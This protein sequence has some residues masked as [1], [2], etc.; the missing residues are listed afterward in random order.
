MLRSAC[1]RSGSAAT[2]MV[3]LLLTARVASAGVEF[4]PP[5]SY[6]LSHPATSVALGD[7][8]GDGDLDAAVG[9]SYAPA[10]EIFLNRGDGTFG[11]ID[12]VVAPAQ[13]GIVVARL[14]GDG[15]PDL[16][17]VTPDGSVSVFRG[18]GDGGFDHLFSQLAGRSASAV[19]AADLDGDGLDDLAILGAFGEDTTT[20]SLGV[21]INQNGSFA[22]P[23]GYSVRSWTRSIAAGDLNGDGRP[24]LA[25]GVAGG[26]Q[27]A[28]AVL[29]NQGDGTLGSSVSF[30]VPGGAPYA[31]IGDLDGD[32]DA[33]LAAA[34]ATTVTGLLNNGSGSFAIAGTTPLYAYAQ[35]AAVADFDGDGR[36]DVATSGDALGRVIAL[37]SAGNGT[38]FDPPL[39]FGSSPGGRGI[40]SGDV[41]GDGHPDV[42]TADLGTS[43][44]GSMTVLV[45][46]APRSCPRK[47]LRSGAG[48]SGVVAADFNADG[49]PDVAAANEDRTLAVMLN[50]GFGGFSDARRYALGTLSQ[51]LAAGDLDADGRPDLVASN[52]IEST[53]T[54][55]YNKGDGSFYGGV[56]LGV[57]PH[58]R[59]VEL[60]DVDGD[61][62]PDLVTADYNDAIYAGSVSVLRNLGNRRFAPPAS[63]AVG[64]GPY[65]VRAANMNKDEMP[66]LVVTNYDGQSVSV[67]M[68]HGDGTFANAVTYA[69]AWNL[70]VTAADFDHDGD[71][72][73]AVTNFKENSVTVLKNDGTGVLSHFARIPVG[74]Q[75]RSIQAAIVKGDG[76]V[77]LVVALSGTSQV[78][79]L[80]NDGSGLFTVSSSTCIVGVNPKA[81]IVTD[82]DH[83]AGQDLATANTGAG[84]IT[85]LPDVGPPGS[86][87]SGTAL[88]K[89]ARR[90]DADAQASARF[91]LGA[92]RPNPARGDA[93]IPFEIPRDALVDLRVYDVAGRVVRTLVSGTVSAGPHEAHWNGADDRGVRMA[94]GTYFYR[95]RAGDQQAVRALMLR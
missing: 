53:V 60:A 5:V 82:F 21:L 90:I 78:I 30:V 29:L 6:P 87:P 46:G 37:G 75:P 73:I 84:T 56:N 32:G 43:G 65:M 34:E 9:S 15:Y 63:Y 67:L 52:F 8:D 68:N 11:L 92:S 76:D 40:A 61:G 2:L 10:V 95:L 7:F 41:S 86:A 77:D 39:Y 20:V 93:L 89:R 81:L 16:A 4:A 66:D 38:F 88:L 45:S 13:A 94:P 14:D 62:R 80:E 79:T 36:A 85:V 27:S 49:A 31:A 35:N 50:D 64:V 17:V 70:S 33:D 22:P 28:V 48:A 12:P 71:N 23:A 54:L 55:Y 83:N 51:N 59:W 18:R 69:N 1:S 58:P 42:V 44:Q 26:Y 47:D 72:D 3:V 91:E 57:G 19:T 25:I 24:D 74:P